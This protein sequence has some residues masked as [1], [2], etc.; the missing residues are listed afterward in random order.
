M[1][2]LDLSIIIFLILSAG[3][4]LWRGFVV[5]VILLVPWIIAIAA[6]I[7]GAPL[8]SEHVLSGIH[9]S[10]LRIMLSFF[11]IFIPLLIVT[12]IFARIACF[13][14]KDLASFSATNRLLGTIFGVIRGAAIVLLVLMLLEG[15]GFN[16]SRWWNDSK[17]TPYA[18]PNVYQSDLQAYVKQSPNLQELINR[19]K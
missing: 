18:L 3:L 10:G 12:R 17:F 9:E 6:A 8:V 15:L 1:N 13:A 2:Y 5:E 14:V 11:V 16:H 4:G 19:L 7:I